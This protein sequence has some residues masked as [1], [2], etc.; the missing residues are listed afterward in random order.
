MNKQLTSRFEEWFNNHSSNIG[1][2]TAEEALQLAADVVAEYEEGEYMR[3]PVR[4]LFEDIDSYISKT[5]GI[6]EQY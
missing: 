2:C 1:Y 5:K 3:R 4:K 6:Y